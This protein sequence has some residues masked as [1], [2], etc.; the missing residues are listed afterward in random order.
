MNGV[1]TTC[2]LRRRFLPLVDAMLVV[3]VEL[4]VC[5]LRGVRH[6]GVR[7]LSAVYLLKV[8]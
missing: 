2:V 3:P 8:A 5:L 6:A 7:C 4:A 1:D